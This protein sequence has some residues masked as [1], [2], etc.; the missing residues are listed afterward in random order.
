MGASTLQTPESSTANTTAGAKPSPASLIHSPASTRRS[1]GDTAAGSNNTTTTTTAEGTPDSTDCCAIGDVAESAPSWWRLRWW[2]YKNGVS[3]V[4]KPTGKVGPNT[5]STTTAAT[6]VILGD[7]VETG[8]IASDGTTPISPSTKRPAAAAVA[9]DIGDGGGGS[10]GLGIHDLGAAKGSND[11][12][13]VKKTSC[14]RRLLT[15]YCD[16]LDKWPVFTKSISSGLIGLLGDLLAQ[17]V[18]WGLANGPGPWSDTRSL[19]RSC[20]VMF[21]GLFINGPLLHYCYEFLEKIMPA[22]ESI[23]A[24]GMQGGVLAVSEEQQASAVE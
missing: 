23:L 9:V 6:V 7:D 19:W 1:Y 2:R 4:C 17:S 21:D 20:A 14:L 18:E 8:S 13:N 11:R 3:A 15:M 10:S 22:E 16:A 24:S 5:S 12:N